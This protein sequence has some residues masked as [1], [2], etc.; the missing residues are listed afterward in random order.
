M[1]GLMPVSIL[2]AFAYDLQKQTDSTQA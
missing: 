2:T 1:V